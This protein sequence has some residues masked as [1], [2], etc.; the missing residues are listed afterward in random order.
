MEGVEEA[1]AAAHLWRAGSCRRQRGGGSAVLELGWVAAWFWR[2]E[3]RQSHEEMLAFFEKT[4]NCM[5]NCR[6]EAAARS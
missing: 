6:A 3:R 4:R 2:A 5:Q 1:A